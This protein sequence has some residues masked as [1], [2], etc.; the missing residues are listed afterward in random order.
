[1]RLTTSQ[2]A[3]LIKSKDSPI[4]F[5]PLCKSA[6]VSYHAIRTRINRGGKLQV[7]EGEKLFDALIDAYPNS[8]EAE[9][10]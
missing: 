10:E 6:G 8:K 5:A 9:N 4:K 3:G 2:V 1:M 7:E